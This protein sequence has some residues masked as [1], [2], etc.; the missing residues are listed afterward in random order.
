M[1]QFFPE[2][3]IFDTVELLYAPPGATDPGLDSDIFGSSN[4]ATVFNNRLQKLVSRTAWLKKFF[5]SG[6]LSELLGFQNTEN[7]LLGFDSGGELAL[8]DFPY[9]WEQLDFL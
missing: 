1:P 3:E 7:K 6:R 9:P 4:H 5:T 2:N 8:L